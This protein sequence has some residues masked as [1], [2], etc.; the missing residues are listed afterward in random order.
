MSLLSLFD[1]AYILTP[2]VNGCYT[3]IF[4]VRI[5]TR[6]HPLLQNDTSGLYAA[7]S[8]CSYIAFSAH[9][10]ILYLHLYGI[11]RYYITLTPQERYSFLF[12][13]FIFHW[14]CTYTHRYQNL[15]IR[16]KF[17]NNWNYY[18]YCKRTVLY[19]IIFC[20]FF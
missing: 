17:G 7:F 16:Y 6:V 4:T 2:F 18:L 9:S 13:S 15:K 10:C 14:L 12:S 8:S 1:Q 5:F 19:L 20:S 3:Y 11:I